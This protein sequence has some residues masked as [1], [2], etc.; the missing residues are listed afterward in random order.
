MDSHYIKNVY[1]A[2]AINK[3]LNMQIEKNWYLYF[4]KNTEKNLA[5]R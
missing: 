3:I 1:I 2:E 5:I 4:R